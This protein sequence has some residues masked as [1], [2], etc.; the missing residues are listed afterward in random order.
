MISKDYVSVDPSKVEVVSNWPRPTTVT[1]IR[2]FLG[3]ADYYRRF[4]EGFSKIAG[5][6]T[7]LTR[8]NVRFTWTKDCEKSLQELKKRLTTTPVLAI[9]YGNDGSPIHWHKTREQKFMEADSVV[10]M[11]QAIKYIRERMKAALDLQKS[12]VNTR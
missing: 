10:V 1:K 8:K 5:P 6:L 11:T 12:Y 3:M 9:P 2:S 7:T 4:V